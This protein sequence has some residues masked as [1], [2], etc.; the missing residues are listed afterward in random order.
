MK[1]L[2][3]KF[4]GIC[5]TCGNP[6]NRGASIAYAGK[7]QVHHAECY[8]AS[9]EPSESEESDPDSLGAVLASDRRLASRGLFV[10]RF[11]SGHVVT[12]NAR[13]RCED[14]PCCGC[15]S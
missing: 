11:S 2:S 1:L 13:G 14:A 12:R 6:F 8:Q 4:P 5:L 3:A 10:T 15:C 7:G 9:A